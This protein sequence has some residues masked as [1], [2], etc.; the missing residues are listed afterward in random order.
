MNRFFLSLAILCAC[1]SGP[2]PGA[3]VAE[4]R[5]FGAARAEALFAWFDGLGYP[6]LKEDPV[7]VRVATGRWS[8]RD[9]GPPVAHTAD[10]FL[11]S[12]EAGSFRLIHLDLA[13]AT[14]ARSAAGTPAHQAVRFRRID[15]GEYAGRLLAAAA[16]GEDE[17]LRSS[18]HLKLPYESRL[19]VLA[20]A[21]QAAG[22]GDLARGLLTHSEAISAGRHWRRDSYKLGLIDDLSTAELWRATLR[23]GYP[24]VSRAQLHEDFSRITRHYAGSRFFSEAERSAEL[25]ARMVDED[26]EHAGREDPADPTIEEKIEELIFQLRDQNGAQTSQPGSCDL[27]YFDRIP[28]RPPSPAQQLVDLGFVTVPA[29]IEAL[30]DERF[31]RSVGYGRNFRYSHY[32]LRVSDGAAAIL[33]RFSGRHF[34]LGRGEGRA[35]RRREVKAQALAWWQQVQSG[36]VREFLTEMVLAGG[37]KSV[38]HATWLARQFP[39]AALAP[40]GRG[41]R[42]ADDPWTRSNLVRVAGGLPGDEPIALLRREM[43]GAPDRRTRASAA[44]ALWRRGHEEGLEAMITEWRRR[45]KVDPGSWGDWGNTLGAQLEFLAGCGEA[46]AI[47]ALADDLLENPIRW[48]YDFVREL[49]T[50]DRAGEW[51]GGRQGDAEEISDGLAAAIEALLSSALHDTAS[52]ERMSGTW[53]GIR[54]SDPRI[55]DLAAH[56]LAR[57]WPDRYQFDLV[58]GAAEREAQRLRLIERSESQ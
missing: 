41:V 42:Q 17:R 53:D 8:S 7:L 52:F 55:C 51:R 29:L 38:D 45:P 36:G 22:R 28:G 10:G 24:G 16:T 1:G 49:H 32:V 44:A 11:L 48:R 35:E 9:G 23:F 56:V 25:L 58:A 4:S 21:C 2:L 39:E 26:L 50:G 19:F 34:W 20:R 3:P 31:T 14:Y 57:R 18:Q 40:I 6:G 13:V 33:S 46:R 27:F 30:D 12:E 54:F 47:A 43:R 37:Q 15:L 5:E